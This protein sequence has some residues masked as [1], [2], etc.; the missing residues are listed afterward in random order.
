MSVPSKV[1]AIQLVKIQP[2]ELN[3]TST[4]AGNSREEAMWMRYEFY[5]TI[6][7]NFTA[8]KGDFIYHKREDKNR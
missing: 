7:S 3:L 5:A 8:H 2:S 4:L 6:I 1:H